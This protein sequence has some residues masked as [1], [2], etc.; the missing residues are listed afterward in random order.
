LPLVLTSVLSVDQLNSN[1][2]T[3]ANLES[4]RMEFQLVHTI[5]RAGHE[6]PGRVNQ[7]LA[8]VQEMT[9][10]SG[11]VRCFI[12]PALVSL[13]PGKWMCECARTEAAKRAASQVHL[14]LVHA[15]D[16]SLKRV[17]EGLA[18]S[19]DSA[20]LPVDEILMANAQIIQALHKMKDNSPEIM[21][22]RGLL[23]QVLVAT[24]H[25]HAGELAEWLV[26]AASSVTNSGIM[27]HPPVW[28]FRKL[29]AGKGFETLFGLAWICVS[30]VA[31]SVAG[32]VFGL[33]CVCYCS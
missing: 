13:A 26:V 28:V 21:A 10:D 16:V 23:Q 9:G 25:L 31:C 7:S 8:T 18:G 14:E 30:S 11:A 1:S 29:Q 2:S 27:P 33:L 15:A 22:L 3:Q 24:I 19:A 5:A 6:L 17:L 32:I 12:L 20:A 4:I